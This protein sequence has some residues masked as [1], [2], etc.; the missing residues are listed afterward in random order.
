MAEEKY[1]VVDIME[2]CHDRRVPRCHHDST[3]PPE[4][5]NRWLVQDYHFADTLTSV[6]EIAAAKTPRQS[7][8]SLESTEDGDP[9]TAPEAANED[10]PTSRCC[11]DVS[12]KYVVDRDAIL[13]LDQVP[14]ARAP[15]S[16]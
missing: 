16:T 5:F 11:A 3:L 7:R 8:K 15:G 13:P 14:R 10:E 1:D 4:A 9:V 2:G 12:R 6:Q